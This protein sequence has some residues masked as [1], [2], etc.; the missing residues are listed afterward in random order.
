VDVVG[1]SGAVG[2][3]TGR[4]PSGNLMC[5][6]GLQEQVT[7]PSAEPGALPSLAPQRG[8]SAPE[9][10]AEPPLVA[11]FPLRDTDPK[12]PSITRI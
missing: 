4:K 2:R 12:R 7:N 9:R 11:A 6:E 3:K 10:R 8:L 1:C 5:L